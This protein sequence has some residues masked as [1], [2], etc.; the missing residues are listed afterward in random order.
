[1]AFEELNKTSVIIRQAWTTSMDQRES[2]PLT[3]TTWERKKRLTSKNWLVLLLSCALVTDILGNIILRPSCST[4]WFYYRSNCY[5]YFQKLRSWSDAEL[6]YQAF[7]KGA[8]LASLLDQK[9]AKVIAKYIWSYQRNQ[10]I[11][12]GLNDDPQKNNNW[13]WIDGNSFLFRA[14]SNESHYGNMACGEMA[15]HSNFLTW[16]EDDCS[17]SRHFV[18][19]YQ[20]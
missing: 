6:E 9:E 2:E 4:G 10:P 15:Y 16:D 1:M 3:E 13:K 11:W 18:C 17:K 14:W 19:K 12:I 8:H 5:G 7:G 20:P